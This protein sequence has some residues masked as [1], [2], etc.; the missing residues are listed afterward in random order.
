MRWR[1]A[2]FDTLGKS[3]AS[4]VAQHHSPKDGLALQVPAACLAATAGRW[5]HDQA[6]GER[7]ESKKYSC[8][9]RK[10]Y[11]G[12]CMT[13]AGFVLPCHCAFLL[14]SARQDYGAWH[15][16]PRKPQNKASTVHKQ[17]D[18]GMQV[19]AM[20]TTHSARYAEQLN[21]TGAVS[22]QQPCRC[23]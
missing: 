8:P 7:L 17:L 2:E 5:C 13:S 21:R 10:A 11:S 15:M 18:P 3:E 19:T 4:T 22:M 9:S 16:L 14:C 12:T 1:A 23:R 6:V 20:G